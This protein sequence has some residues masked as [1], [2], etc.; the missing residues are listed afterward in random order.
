MGYGNGPVEVAVDNQMKELQ[1][2]S[3]LDHTV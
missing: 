1:D 3:N 2:F